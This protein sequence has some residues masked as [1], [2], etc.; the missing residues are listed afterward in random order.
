[1]HARIYQISKERVNKEDYIT[2]DIYFEYSNEYMDYVCETDTYDEDLKDL[3]EYVLPKDCFCL[4]KDGM[5]RYKGGLHKFV[6]EWIRKLQE[7]TNNPQ[8]RKLSY[9]LE[10]LVLL[11]KHPTEYRSLIYM[12]GYGIMTTGEWMATI[13]DDLKAGDSFYIGNVLD[14]HY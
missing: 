6:E 4:E 5:I 8:G 12:K 10:K 13:L 11:I 9:A 3:V 1:M 7:M 14:F 2:P